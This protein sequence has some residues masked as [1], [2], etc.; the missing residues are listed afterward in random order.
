M[1]NTPVNNICAF[2]GTLGISES[3]SASG[4]GV[5]MCSTCLERFHR[6]P[7]SEEPWWG[8]MSDE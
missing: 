6:A 2:C 8:G 4:L 7:R 3:S 1:D 5:L